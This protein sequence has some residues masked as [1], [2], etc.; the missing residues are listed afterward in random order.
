MD[1]ETNVRPHSVISIAFDR[2]LRDGMS[3]RM[4]IHGYTS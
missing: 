1:F 2:G 4:G 3:Q